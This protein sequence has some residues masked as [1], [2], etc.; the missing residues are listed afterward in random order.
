LRRGQR[1]CRSSTKYC[2]V[3]DGVL[4]V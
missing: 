1:N 4:S 3:N 2:A